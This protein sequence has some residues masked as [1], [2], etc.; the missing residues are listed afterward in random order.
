MGLVKASHSGVLVV[1]VIDAGG[2]HAGVAMAPVEGA[3]LA[4]AL[5]ALLEG[6]PG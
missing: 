3:K 6:W 5:L 1:T 4:H 2:R